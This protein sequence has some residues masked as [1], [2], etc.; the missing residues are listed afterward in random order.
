MNKK[1]KLKFKF[2]KSHFVN[3]ILCTVVW[4]MFFLIENHGSQFLNLSHLD[5]AFEK[6]GEEARSRY[7][8]S[9][10]KELANL[11]FERVFEDQIIKDYKIHQNSIFFIQYHKG[12]PEPY[13]DQ[14]FDLGLGIYF[15]GKSDFDLSGQKTHILLSS[16]E[17]N[18]QETLQLL[19]ETQ[20]YD[21]KSFGFLMNFKSKIS[22]SLAFVLFAFDFEF[23]L[24]QYEIIFNSTYLSSDP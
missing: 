18:K 10:K 14:E 20:S 9:Q 22:G 15:P 16:L 8:Y 11:F 6:F 24:P 23:Y 3:I 19:R 4:L 2:L 7:D 5:Q 17:N 1:D 21:L 13:K 12:V